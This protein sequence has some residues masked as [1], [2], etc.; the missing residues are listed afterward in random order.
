MEITKESDR[1]VLNKFWVNFKN[2]VISK[3]SKNIFWTNRMKFL[4][5]IKKLTKFWLKI[6][7]F[8]LVF[9]EGNISCRETG[10]AKIPNL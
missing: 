5:K 1:K 10:R 6:N 4:K 2:F 7:F 3:K 9:F 8:K